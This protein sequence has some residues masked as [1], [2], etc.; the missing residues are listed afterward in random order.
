MLPDKI[1][2]VANGEME[3]TVLLPPMAEM[4][5]EDDLLRINLEKDDMIMMMMVVYNLNSIVIK[6][7][8]PPIYFLWPAL[9]TSLS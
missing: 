9:L 2:D 8:S 6:H 7:N 4:F 5:G 3:R 1:E